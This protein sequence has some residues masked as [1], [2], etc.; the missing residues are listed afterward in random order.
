MIKDAKGW[1]H[2]IES[3]IWLSAAVCFMM[4]LYAPLELL[5][6]NQDEFWFDA[7]ILVSVMLPVFILTCCLSVLA[8]ALIERKSREAYRIALALYFFAF[9]ALYVQGNLLISGLPAL[10]GRAIDWSLYTG[11]RIKSAALWGGAIL[12]GIVFF[13]RAS[14]AVFEKAVKIVSICMILMLSVTLFTLALSNQGFARKP[15]VSI[16]EKNMFQMSKDSNFVIFVLDAVDGQTLSGMMDAS[17]EYRD[18]FEDFVC[19]DNVV[20]AYPYTQYSVPYILS[21]MWFENE[22]EFKEYE[23]KAYTSSPLFETLEKD[24]Y[25]MAVY[26]AELF[27]ENEGM[28]R[29]ENMLPNGRGVA[30]KWAFARWQILMTGFKY[31]PY[32]LKRFCF[33]NPAAFNELKIRPEG[34]TLFTDSNLRFYENLLREGITETEQKCFRFIH[35]EGG[36][37]PFRY[38][39][40]VNVIENGTYKGNLEASLTV[41]KAYLEKLKE[42]GVYDNTAIIVMS[43]HGYNVHNGE[44]CHGRQNPVFLVK[45]IGEKHALQISDAPLSFE[46][47]Q[48][49]YRRLLAGADGEQISD[50]KSD[51]QRERRY[52]L[53]EYLKEDHLT[54]WIQPGPAYDTESMYETGNVYTR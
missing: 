10:D 21:G 23:E 1:I 7:Y 9:I 16:T 53:H 35:L 54:E 49:A 37:V 15:S 33:V 36:H 3:G 14:K 28:A 24:G 34:E 46:D 41:T 31:A 44:D 12:A 22:T 17:P 11:E 48:E 19:Y 25:T 18:I 27:L 32:D 4:F 42:S 29:F 47:L 2:R 40:D 13:R 43:D 39:R 8:L 45:G 20:C 50:W 30:D 38:D 26:E 51:D 5:F 6:T 52:L